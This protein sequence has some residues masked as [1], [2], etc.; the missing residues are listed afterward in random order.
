MDTIVLKAT[1]NEDKE[2]LRKL[3]VLLQLLKVNVDFKTKSK[4]YESMSGQVVYVDYLIVTY[5]DVEIYKKLHRSNGRKKI[6]LTRIALTVDE[7]RKMID[8]DTAD[9]VAENL[10]ISRSTL[11]RRLKSAEKNN[12]K[13]I[14]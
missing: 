2:E 3:A 9:V 11:F 12:S 8:R 4:K 5:D 10:G 7:V 14:Y 1:S 13:Y 6:S